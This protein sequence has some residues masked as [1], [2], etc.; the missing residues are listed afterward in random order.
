MLSGSLKAETQSGKAGLDA[1]LASFVSSHQAKIKQTEVIGEVTLVRM[2]GPEWGFAILQTG[3]GDQ[4]ITGRVNDLNEGSSYVITGQTKNHPKYGE[5]IELF[6]A[7]PH[8][9]ASKE[10]L[11]KF[12][13]KNFKGIG[14]SSAKKFIANVFENQGQQG[15][16]DLREQLVNEPW[17]VDFSTIKRQGVFDGDEKDK[18]IIAYVQRDLATKIQGLNASVIA[19]LAEYLVVAMNAVR[20][21]HKEMATTDPVGLAWKILSENPYAPISRVANYGFLAADA[22]GT[23]VKIDRN[24]PVRLIALAS[25]A[26]KIQC[27][28]FGH[29]YLKKPQAIAAISKIDSQVSAEYALELA[30]SAA[31]VML[32]DETQGDACYYPGKLLLAEQRLA[33]KVAKLCE[34]STSLWDKLSSKSRGNLAIVDKIQL[35]AKQLGGAFKNGLDP[36]QAQALAG[37][38]TSEVRLHTVTAAPGAGKTAVMEVLAKLLP[39]SKFLFCAPTGKGAKVLG[40]RVRSVGA[41]ASTIHSMLAGNPDEGFF[42]DEANTLTTD[43]L[44]IDEGSMPDLEL[45]CATLSAVDENAHVIV[46]GDKD[47]LPSIAPGSFLADL[48]KIPQ[49]DHHRLDVVHRNHGGILEVIQEV[50]DGTITPENKDGLTFSGGLPPVEMGFQSVLSEYLM[51]VNRSGFEGTALLMSR[52]KGNISEPGWNT[53]YANEVL[54]QVCNPNA[55]R[56]PGSVLAIGDRIIIKAN[57]SL[58]DEEEEGKDTRVVNGDTGTITGFVE[59]EPDS[60]AGRRDA[61]IKSVTLKLDDGRQIDFPG[62]ALSSL[63]HSYALTVHAAQGSEYKDVIAVMTPGVST[64]VN[65]NMLYTCLSRARSRLSVYGDNHALRQIAQTPLPVRNSGLVARVHNEMSENEGERDCG[66]EA[67]RAN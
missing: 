38:L 51:A 63:Q 66:A 1:R 7:K 4:K 44:V 36:S 47:Q 67:P 41:T 18:T 34:Q 30:L 2:F 20:D 65:R 28:N 54:R 58:D 62:F 5:S 16:L 22:I 11:E 14:D 21:Q 53:T 26:I 3:N 32:D 52:R 13:K 6:A 24:A 31:D 49:V 57:M 43:V 40:N 19:K 37:I 25:Y 8:V 35:T 27:E 64:F 45:A 23:V 60:K 39:D 9:E 15:L 48:L 33:K 55:P 17:N 56:V 42:Y 50:R 46:L 59:K 10:A 12:V 29:V 61:G